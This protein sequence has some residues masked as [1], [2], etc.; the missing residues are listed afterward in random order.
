MNLKPLAH[1]IA[2]AVAAH[3]RHRG[4][5]YEGTDDPGCW[6]REKMARRYNSEVGTTADLVVVERLG[7][8]AARILRFYN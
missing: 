4:L 5:Y 7:R 3:C 6:E 1:A 8:E 2:C